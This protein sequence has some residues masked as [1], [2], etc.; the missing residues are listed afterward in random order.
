M[1]TLTAQELYMSH[2]PSFNFE[3]D[4]EQLVAM[5]LDVGFVTKTG[6]DQYTVNEDY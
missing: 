2:A 5:A 1:N 6:D 3:L 4:K